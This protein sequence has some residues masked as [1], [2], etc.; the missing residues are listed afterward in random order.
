MS[1]VATTN[2][3]SEMW[4]SVDVNAHS[5]KQTK[6]YGYQQY[7][8][9]PA[10]YYNYQNYYPQN[11]EYS[12]IISAE[13]NRKI[14]VPNQNNDVVKSEPNWQEYPSNYLNANTN[15]EMI[16]KWRNMNYYTQEHYENYGN[17]EKNIYLNNQRILDR[18]EEVRS[19]D[20]PGQ[21]SIPESFGSPQSATNIFQSA[22][23][24][25]DD[26]PQLRSLL[27]KPKTNK[28]PYY[29]KCKKMYTQ[30][31]RSQMLYTEEVNDWEKT[32]ETAAEK[33]CNL[34]QF[35]GGFENVEGQTSIKK[36]SVGG[37]P[38]PTKGAQSSQ[39]LDEPC[40][41]V[42]RVEVGENN[43]DYGESNMATATDVQT[44]YP[45]MKGI[46]G[47]LI[48]RYNFWL[49]DILMSIFNSLVF[50]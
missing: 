8:T 45:W 36:D 10:N 29:V 22:S 7:H 30:E 34:S 4:N 5:V 17:E 14:N 43:A 19:I 15:L 6:P 35:H 32:N 46:G 26:S 1:S 2:R 16:Q 9:T 18:A 38:A 12:N 28:T 42:T 13:Y 24:G 41:D 25:V 31:T 44:F 23:P 3:A 48:I 11:C 37:A 50:P 27:T 39:D 49:I 20:S 21:C 40:Q 33:E 47:K